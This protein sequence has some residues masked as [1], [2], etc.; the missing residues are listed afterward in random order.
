MG[1]F[2]SFDAAAQGMNV[3]QTQMDVISHNI[4]H[5]N[6]P[7]SKKQVAIIRPEGA[8]T[9]AQFLPPF[10]QASMGS[11][12]SSGSG[13][14]VA[15]ITEVDSETKYVYDPDNPLAITEGKWKGYVAKSSINIIEEMT[16]LITASRAYEANAA[17]VDATK[18]MAMRA[19]DIGRNA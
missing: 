9:F 5:G 15:G 3:A 18:Y 8:P 1:I 17:V 13:V 19:L 4:A 6:V 10:V 12:L 11:G 16:N 2:K 14:E 7:G